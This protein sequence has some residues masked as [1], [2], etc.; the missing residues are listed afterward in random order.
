MGEL[1]GNVEGGLFFLGSYAAMLALLTP[2]RTVAASIAA[3]AIGGGPAGIV[4]GVITRRLHKNHAENYAEQI[5]RGGIIL[6]VR[7]T[8]PEREK[9]ACDILAQHSGKDIQVH[10]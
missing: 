10:D 2:A 9:I 7:V 4:G 1:E 6:W 3:I 8:N 5:R